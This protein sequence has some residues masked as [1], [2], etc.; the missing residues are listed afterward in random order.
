MRIPIIQ[1]SLP[2]TTY[3][4]AGRVLVKGTIN[5]GGN[6][7]LHLSSSGSAHKMPNKLHEDHIQATRNKV[8]NGK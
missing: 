8:A 6:F 2:G 7:L 4:F 3:S 5:F 1:R